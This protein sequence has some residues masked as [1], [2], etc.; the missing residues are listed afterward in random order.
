MQDILKMSQ[1]ELSRFDIIKRVVDKM[2]KQ[3]EAARVLCLS[4]RQTQRLVQTY[5]KEGVKGLISKKRGK[6]SNHRFSKKIKT[7]ARELIESIYVDFGPKF[8]SEKLEENHKIKISKETLRQWMIEWGVWEPSRRKQ[9]QIHQQRKRRPCFGELV[10][11]DGSPHDWFE[12]RGDSCCLISFIDDATS[13][14]VNLQ[15]FPVEN[16]QAYFESCKKHLKKHGRPLIYY[17]DRHGIF[18]VNH[19]NALGGEGETQF[20]RAMKELGI[21]TINANSPQAKGRVERH[22]RTLQDRLVKEM[23]LKNISDIDTANQFLETFIND[24]NNKFGKS[25]ASDTDLHQKAIPKEEVLNVILSERYTRKLSKNLEFSF[26]GKTYQVIVEKGKIG[27]GLRKATI[28]I[29][30]DAR[31]EI[32]VWYKNRYLDFKEFKK[33]KEPSK[34]VTSKEIN[35]IAD[36]IKISHTK[37]PVMNHPWKRNSFLRMVAKKANW[38]G[39]AKFRGTC[40]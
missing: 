4:Y 40:G 21:Q 2:I 35:M 8:A 14:A 31:S 6:A 26:E 25:P 13:R 29:C 20:E 23:R 17:S 38:K 1:K 3:T 7:N 34:I 24:Y 30:R 19:K 18:R 37:K 28:T 27:Y 36:K 16:T 12:G 9:A 22:N 33:E 10:Q 15:F 39:C 5:L 11:I 32:K